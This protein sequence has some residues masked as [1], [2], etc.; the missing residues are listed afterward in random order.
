MFRYWLDSH[1]PSNV[2]RENA[3]ID[4][5]VIKDIIDGINTEREN[6]LIK[7]ANLLWLKEQ[8]ESILE[9]YKAT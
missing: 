6:D 7:K 2:I 9:L 3:K 1:F 5:P 4:L 8:M